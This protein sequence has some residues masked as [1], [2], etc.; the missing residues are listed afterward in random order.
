MTALDNKTILCVDDDEIILV[1]L[2]ETIEPE[3]YTVVVANTPAEAIE[4]IKK[5]E[6]AVIMSDQRMP[7]MTGLEFFNHVKDIQPNSSRILITGVLSLK[8]IINAVNEGEIYRFLSKPWIREELIVTIHNAFQRYALVSANEQLT[9]DTLRL[10]ESLAEANNQLGEQLR[11]VKR[12]N[13]KLDRAHLALGRNFD[14]SLELSYRLIESYHPLL[15]KESASV[16]QLCQLMIDTGDFTPEEA[17]TLKVSAWLK[18]IGYVTIHRDLIQLYRSHPNELSDEETDQIKNAPI[19]AQNMV[20]FVDH[21]QDVG[22]TIRGQ[23]ERWDGH[24]YPD[25]YAGKLIPKLA[26]YIAVATWF[27]ESAYSREEAIDQI[28]QLSGKAFDPDA[29]RLFTKATGPAKI[30]GNI[31]EILFNELMPGMK[32]ARDIYSPSGLLL[33]PEGTTLD[34]ITLDKVTDYNFVNPITQRI[35]VF[36]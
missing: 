12:T 25:C 23:Y 32:L 2:R 35:L 34:N 6:F 31:R 1:A 9:E 28:V 15:G 16:V 21:L 26:R 14:H 27:V 30:P 24:G 29:V 22:R 10:N 18:N 19:V 13:E 20:S 5:Q 33:I 4:L 36:A 8:T 17:Q 11:K 3:G 7:D